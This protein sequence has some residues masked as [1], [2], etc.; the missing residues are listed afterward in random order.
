MDSLHASRV[1]E[2]V[3]EKYRLVRL[4]GEGGMGSVY[5]ARHDLIG[6]RFAVKFL[7]A[8]LAS[9][10]EI[11]ARFRR[12]AQAAGSLENE[13]IAAV[14]DFGSSPD[15]APYIVMEFLEGEDVAKTLAR[16]GPMS[17]QRAAHILIQVCR[18][19]FAAH[20]RGI[21]H[22]DL[23]PEN[24]LLQQRGDGQ[25]LV[26]ILDF[27]IAK[28][29]STEG[30]QNQ[31]RTG[32]TLGTPYYMP[33]EQARGQK[34]LD[35][36]A[37]IYALGVI[38]FELLSGRKPHDGEN[39]NSILYSILMQAAPRI[40]TF[41]SDLPPDLAAIVHRA[42]AA[43]PN[44]RFQTVSE[45]SQALAPYTGRSITPAPTLGHASTV[46][47]PPAA[48]QRSTSTRAPVAL[49]PSMP[50]STATP[51]PRSNAGLFI[52]LAAVLV[53]GVGG[54]AWF[55]TRTPTVA[56]TAPSA[57]PVVAAVAQPTPVPSLAPTPVAPPPEPP[58]PEAAASTSASAAPA[59]P[60]PA[61]AARPLKGV[62]GSKPQ[63][64][65]VVAPAPA[66]ATPPPAARPAPTPR[67]AAKP[68]DDLFAP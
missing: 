39:Y 62:K 26:K 1:G 4:L 47:A 27:G 55:F 33:P 64:K 51:V 30:P 60:A 66:A 40:E 37:D 6:R 28:L 59:A 20:G 9:H 50:Y 61:V 45:L 2:V 34:E 18:G 54:A 12:E 43:D 49:T 29:K 11:L 16:F 58:A 13:N 41:R 22:R 3:G 23:K 25:D 14:T 67:P 46:M 36:R 21:V 56:E 7:H 10:P 44:D 24:L 31:T 32:I 35:E 38:L 48:S 19:L 17:I 68:D 8:E 53:A 5:E 65:P 15:G 52:G 42:M 63:E 57:A